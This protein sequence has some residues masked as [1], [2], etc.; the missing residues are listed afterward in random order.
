MDSL[1]VSQCEP[2]GRKLGAR[3]T[4]E[5]THTARTEP[6]STSMHEQILKRQLWPLR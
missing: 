5:R 1:H 3:L 4:Y 2:V 6:K